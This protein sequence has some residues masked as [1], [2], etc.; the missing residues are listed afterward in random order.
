MGKR[1]YVNLYYLFFLIP[2]IGIKCTTMPVSKSNIEQKS[3]YIEQ[4]KLTYFRQMLI[5]GYNNSNS[6]QEIINTDHSGFTEPIL[7]EEDYILLDSL[8]TL[9]NKE[10]VKDSIDGINRA[11]GS[12]GKRPLEYILK[13]LNSKFLDSLAINRYKKYIK[14]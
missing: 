6:I 4:I 10:M 2:I 8:T 7:S 9:D 14:N 1:K 12:N 11:E 3:I 5:K 13:K